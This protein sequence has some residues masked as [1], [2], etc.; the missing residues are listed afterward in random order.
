MR[1]LSWSQFSMYSQCPF[2]WYG[3]Y[4]KK[5]LPFVKNIHFQVGSATHAAIEFAL[6]SWNSP[7]RKTVPEMVSRFTNYLKG[8]GISDPDQLQYWTLIG[9]NMLLAW[10]R[11]ASVQNMRIEVVERRI[12]LR[13]TFSGV[14]DCIADINGQRTI[15]DWKTSSRPR[16][17]KGTDNDGQLTTYIWLDGGHYDTAVMHGVL[18]KGQ[19]K[20]QVLTSKRTK[21]D[22]N[23]FLDE[24]FVM[25]QQIMTYKMPMDVERKPS[26]LC[27]Y[28]DLYPH[29][30]EGEDDF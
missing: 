7:P 5:W 13:N 4:I 19:S 30:C 21:E 10:Y 2:K 6:S 3:V 18:L 12:R 26:K 9:Q 22:V 23:S 24:L 29:Y 28:C 25:R 16:T 17:Q 15:I 8:D 11:W 20:F 1:R 27:G 14:I